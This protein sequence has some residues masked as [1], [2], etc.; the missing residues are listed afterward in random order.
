ME[1]PHSSGTID[2]SKAFAD[3]I[4]LAIQYPLTII[5]TFFLCV[6]GGLVYYW[7]SPKTYE[8]KMIL[9]SDILSE[10][11]ALKL[12]ENINA[13]IKDGDTDYLA[14]RLSL[15]NDEAQL[16]REF[17]V[18]SALTPMSQQT[19]EQDK[20]IVVISVRVQ[21]NAILPK[22]QAG[23]I[24]YLS[25]NPYIK[26]RVEENRKKYEGLIAAL[27]REIRLMDTLKV[28]IEKGTFVT[29]KA[30][31][32]SLIDVSKLYEVSAD[33]HEKKL[34][35]VIELAIVDSVQVVEDFSTYS[36]P[37]WPKLSIVLLASLVLAMLILFL[38]FS[39][40]ISSPSTSKNS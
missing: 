14:S 26:K 7:M 11:Y 39:Y 4:R 10:S 25:N 13:H 23:I 8:S 16:L 28:K 21:D 37:V 19:R 9:Q 38:I 31:G 33:L 17:K 12:A 5:L 6:G 29:S 18:A 40:R 3:F 1:N 2:L 35:W 20:I 22:L 30:N 36:K 32:I 15:T 34:N 24:G 27:D